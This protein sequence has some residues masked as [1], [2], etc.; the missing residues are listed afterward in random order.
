MKIYELSFDYKYSVAD[1]IKSKDGT[2]FL[3]L[4]VSTPT[5]AN[6]FMYGWLQGESEIIPDFICIMM[7]LWG[8]KSEITPHLKKLMPTINFQ[9]IEVGN[10]K[11]TMFFNVPLLSGVLNLKKSSVSRLSNGDI[12]RIKEAV[13]YPSDY[14]EIFIVEEM[15]SSCFCNEEFKKFIENKFSGVLFKECKIKS[16]S[17]F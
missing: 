3:D 7:N 17:W 9:E 2:D 13:F 6:N 5:I 16:K 14:P 8:C 10:L 15:P 4:S 11:Y 12:L 1:I